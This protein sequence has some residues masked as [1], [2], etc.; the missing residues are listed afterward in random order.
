MQ[1][2]QMGSVEKNICAIYDL[3]K[4]PDT[5]NKRTYLTL[6]VISRFLDE[7]E[8]SIQKQIDFERDQEQ[9]KRG[10]LPY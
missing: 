6:M 4:V 5:L 10:K 1:Y 3:L 7:D 9:L 2:A 8:P